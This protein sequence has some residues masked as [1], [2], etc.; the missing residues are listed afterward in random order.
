MLCKKRI[1]MNR[2]TYSYFLSTAISFLILSSS[3]ITA[4]NNVAYVDLDKKISNISQVIFHISDLDDN[5][6]SPLHELKELIEH[7]FFVV[8][9]DAII[10]TLKYA[11]IVLQN[12]YKKLDA[13]K[14]KQIA[15]DL[16]IIIH[17]VLDGSLTIQPDALEQEIDEAVTRKP[18]KKIRGNI[19]VSGKSFLKK[20]VHSKQGI[21]LDGK[22]QVGKTASFKNNAT[23]EKDAIVVGNFSATDASI[24]DLFVTNLTVENCIDDL[25]VTNLS[26]DNADIQNLTFGGSLVISDLTL[27]SLSVTD[28]VIDGSLKI[29]SF[30][31]A[32]VIHNNASGLCSSSLIVNADVDSA[33]GIVDTKLA[34]ISTAG[35][36]A[37]SATTA[38]STDTANAIVTRNASGNFSTNMITLNGVVNNPTDAATKAYVDSIVPGG[39]TTGANIGS[40]TGLI[41]KNK[42]ANTINFK[43]LVNGAHFALTN[44][45]NDITLA[46][47]AT[48]TNTAGTIVARDGSGNFTTNMITLSGTVTNP[49]DAA[50]KAYVDSIVPSGSTTGA[51]VGSGTGLIFRDK[52]GNNINFKTLINGAHFTLT[53]NTNDI[54]LATDATSANTANTIVARDGSGNFS[55]GT[56]TAN[57]IGNAST[58]TTATT[59]TNFTGS[60]SGDV[61][62][63]QGATAVSTVG[64]QTA[65]NIAA[66]TVLTNAATNV[67]TASAIVRRDASGNFV[68]NMITLNGTVT[69]PTDAATKAYV[70]SIVPSGSTTGANV[71][72]GTGLIFRDKTGNDINFKTLIN[73]AHFALTNNT[74]DITL[75]TDATSANT[76]ST[77]VARNASGNFVTNMITLNGTTTNPTD[78]ATKAYVDAAVISATGT[79]LNLPNTLVQRDG[80]GSFAAQVVS[81]VDTV[82]SGNI[83]V[84]NSTNSTIGNIFK[85]SNRFIHNFG[86]NNTFVG[87]NAGSFTTSGSGANSAFGVNALTAITTGNNNIA[88]G[89]QAGQTLT[90]GSNNVYINANAALSSENNIIRIGTSQTG[91]FIAGISTSGVS[92]DSVVVDSDGKLGITV[93]SERFKHDIQDMSNES[94]NIMKLRPVTFVYNSDENN[95]KQYGLIAEEVQKIFPDIVVKDENGLPYT[96]RYH[97]LPVMLL[98]ELQKQQVTI[99]EMR[100]DINYLRTEMQKLLENKK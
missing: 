84:N 35:K 42:T 54:T 40:G 85:G 66:A 33:A 57:L 77:I 68:T 64:G 53:N 83:Q 63:T 69:N 31:P 3:C 1:S 45:A 37:N 51:N 49:T 5:K 6:E 24:N 56:I 15:K 44:N 39:S 25:C 55:A 43:T 75:A 10:E 78:A 26:V 94:E 29:S 46:T 38:T 18:T 52:T 20:H 58:A 62:G 87:V 30:T 8:E 89:Y 17:Q 96:V 2:M 59:A 82:V 19:Y 71:G 41:F 28:E 4:K 74:N 91:C 95:T 32:G 100:K 34:T 14:A 23:F 80:T 60:L 47:D 7:E 90:S 48:N 76:A 97:L 16:D 88:I 92:G 13:R 22:L 36:V 21:N 27:T 11:E 73:G 70:D 61:T 65:A 86:V 72:S 93:S 81:V 12:N 50:T 79:S 9:Y 98:N 99:E 67:N